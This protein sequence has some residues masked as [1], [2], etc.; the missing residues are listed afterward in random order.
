VFCKACLTEQGLCQNCEEQRKED[1]DEEQ[2]SEPEKS[3]TN[4]SVQPDSM[5]KA[6]VHAGHD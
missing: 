4:A 5:G 2:D 3:E 1:S 6:I